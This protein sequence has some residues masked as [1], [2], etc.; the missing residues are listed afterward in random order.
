[1]RN[2]KH[3]LDNDRFELLIK[4]YYSGNRDNEEELMAMF[5]LLIVNILNGFNFAVDEDDAK[6]ET[7][8][9]ILK[10]LKN[11]SSEKGSA[12][13]YFTTSIMNNLRLIYTKNKKHTEK[14]NRYIEYKTGYSPSSL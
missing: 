1:M 12:F 4:E 14:I 8:L 2:N 11:F 7:F 6:Q 5:D 10:I 3:Y 13:N 9:L